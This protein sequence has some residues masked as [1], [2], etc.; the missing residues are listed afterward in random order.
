MMVFIA[1]D[2]AFPGTRLSAIPA[3]RKNGAK[4]EIWVDPAHA[5]SLKQ[6][7]TLSS[8]STYVCQYSNFQ[9]NPSLPRD[10]F[11]FKTN[12]QTVYRTQ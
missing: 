3:V 1:H 2:L 7:F 8:T 10:A 4:V 12:G 9:F 6:V 5:V 11:T